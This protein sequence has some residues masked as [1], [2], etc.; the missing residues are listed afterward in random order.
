MTE[1]DSNT[2]FFHS[3]ASARK[4]SNR[5][6]ALVNDND[7]RIDSPSGMCEI[8]LGYFNELFAGDTAEEEIDYFESPRKITE[9]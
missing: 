8:V 2:R 7:E 9:E 1:R 4:K 3:S 5:I 6:A